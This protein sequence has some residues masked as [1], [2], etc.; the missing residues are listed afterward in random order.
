MWVASLSDGSD[1]VSQQTSAQADI[2]FVERRLGDDLGEA[3]T[4][5]ATKRR[6]KRAGYSCKS[7]VAL[8]R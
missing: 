6:T 5:R 4:D 1:A 3:S 8:R 7:H 2:G